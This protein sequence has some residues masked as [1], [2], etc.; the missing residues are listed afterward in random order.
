MPTATDSIRIVLADDNADAATMLAKL[1]MVSGY[2][3]VA[4][5]ALTK[6]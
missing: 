5:E 4:L 3:V 6:P 2:R 1:L